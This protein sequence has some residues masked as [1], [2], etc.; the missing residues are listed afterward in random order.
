LATDGKQ[1]GTIFLFTHGASR[2]SQ[3]HPHGALRQDG[4]RHA[5]GFFGKR[6]DGLWMHGQGF[7]P[8]VLDALVRV[9][10]LTFPSDPALTIRL[11]IGLERGVGGTGV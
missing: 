3:L 1:L 4:L 8:L 9:P 2:I 5:D 6:W 10:S 11:W 7:P